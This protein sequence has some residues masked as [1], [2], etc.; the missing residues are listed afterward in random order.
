MNGIESGRF[1]V[2]S[3]V[4]EMDSK[5]KTAYKGTGWLSC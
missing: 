1:Q 5:G 2:E 3:T 4:S